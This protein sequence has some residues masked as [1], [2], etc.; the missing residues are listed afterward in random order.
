MAL[1]LTLC[2]LQY[3]SIMIHSAFYTV[4]LVSFCGVKQLQHKGDLAFSNER[5]RT[6]IASLVCFHDRC[7]GHY[8][9]LGSFFHAVTAAKVHPQPFHQTVHW[10]LKLNS[11]QWIET[12]VTY[13]NVDVSGRVQH[14]ATA[15][16]WVSCSLFK[17]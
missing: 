14:E 10:S 7:N 1:P 8:Q 9:Y 16:I 6:C 15:G 3:V 12:Q 11:K 5:S 17:M 13:W 2:G 4:G